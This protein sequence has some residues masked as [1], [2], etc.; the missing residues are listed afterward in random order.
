MKGSTLAIATVLLGST[1]IAAPTAHAYITDDDACGSAPAG[2]SVP[3]GAVVA[4]RGNGGAIS[5]L[6]DAISEWYSHQMLSHGVG[7]YAW[8]SHATMKTPGIHVNVFGDDQVEGA[9][10][11]WGYPGASQIDMG[12][13]YH[14]LYRGGGAQAVSW[15]SGGLDGERTADYLWNTLPYCGSVSS[16]PCYV[17]VYSQQHSSEYMYL[18]ARKEGGVSYRHGYGFYQYQDQ[19]AVHLGDDMSAI[20]WGQHCSTFVAWGLALATGRVIAPK[21][22]SNAVVYPATGTLHSSVSNECDDGAGWFGGIFVNCGDIADQIVNC[23]TA[24][25]A[26]NLSR[27]DDDSSSTWQSWRTTGTATSVSPD[28]VIGRGAAGSGGGPWAGNPEQPV[29]WNNGGSTYGCF[30]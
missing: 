25:A 23:F 16:G 18:V 4:S 22:Y 2:W 1:V 7:T 24:Q 19:R 10:I 3:K 30:F 9:D 27:C 15:V 26:G 12:A 5:K 11:K 17:G 8:V 21:T 14:A 28:R 6:M 29:Y 13:T 20:G